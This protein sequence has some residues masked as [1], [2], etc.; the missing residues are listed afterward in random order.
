MNKLVVFSDLH[1]D[2]DMLRMIIA[3]AEKEKADSILCAGDLGIHHSTII[4]HMIR[5]CAI[6]FSIV[7]GNCDSPWAFI[8]VQIP[9]PPIHLIIDFHSRKIL[10]T[11]GDR[12]P[13][14]DEAPAKLTENDIFIYG[15]S[16]VVMLEHS[17]HSPYILNPG[18]A[19]RPRDQHEPSFAVITEKEISIREIV[20]GRV[21]PGY[22]KGLPRE[23]LSNSTM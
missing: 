11:H 8:E 10:L 3:R 20:S 21:I 23:D 14:W 19:S 9:V 12:I 6:P 15:H 4:A 2:I 22:S 18:S 13:S 1:G 16:H 7:R 17:K 5:T